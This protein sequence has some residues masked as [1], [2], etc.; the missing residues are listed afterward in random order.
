MAQQS[1]IYDSLH[2]VA[3]PI[4]S[5]GKQASDPG[6]LQ[7]IIDACA[8]EKAFLFTDGDSFTVL[9]PIISAGKNKLLIWVA[10]SPEGNAYE[11]FMPYIIDR[12]KEIGVEQ[13]EFWTA[14]PEISNYIS[15]K[16]WTKSFEVWNLEV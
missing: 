2:I 8:N 11:K 13:L 4:I 10:F 14:I 6:L 7:E 5:I 12:A 3:D 1:N 15:K 9:K 16:N